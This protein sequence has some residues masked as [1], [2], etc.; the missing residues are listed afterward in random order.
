MSPPPDAEVVIVGAGV[1][2]LATARALALA[3]REVVLCEQFEVGHERGSSHGG[4]R[5]VRLSYPEERYVRLAQEA[6]P[7]WRELEA[8]CGRALLEQPGSLD[9]GDW[10][11]EPRRTCGV[12]RAV[13]GAGRR[14]DRAP[15]SDP[16]RAGRE[17]PLPGRRRLRLRRP[18]AASAAGSRR[19]R[20]RAG[21]RARARRL[22]RR[23]RRRRR[24]R[25]GARAGRRRHR[26]RLGAGARGRRRHPDA[27]DDVLLLPRRAGAVRDRAERRQRT[28]LRA[29]GAGHRHEGGL[30]PVGADRRSGRAGWAGRGDR[31]ADGGLGGTALPRHRSGRCASRPASTRGAR[32]TSSSSNARAGSSSARRA[33]ATASSSRR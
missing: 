30:A 3:G 33:A 9:L 5:I 26:R 17:R 4:S 16:D 25:R 28:R 2:G 21:P 19:G 14:R 18:R 29:R 15:L 12:R 24:R 13:R 10:R 22:G 31:G 32:T 8:E 11:A 1:M 6:Y 20:G 7:L 23:G 27:R